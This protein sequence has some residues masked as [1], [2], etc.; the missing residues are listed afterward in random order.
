MI[1]ASFLPSPSYS[2][3]NDTGHFLQAEKHCTIGRNY[4]GV[5]SV[6]C[7]EQDAWVGRFDDGHLKFELTY[8]GQLSA[9]HVEEIEDE[10]I[11]NDILNRFRSMNSTCLSF[12]ECAKDEMLA[13]TVAGFDNC[14]HPLKILKLKH[15]LDLPD[16]HIPMTTEMGTAVVC[17]SERGAVLLDNGLSPNYSGRRNEPLSKLAPGYLDFF[18]FYQ[19]N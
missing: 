3:Q 14:P 15:Y 6:S 12:K 5:P 10:G 16:A 1:F 19:L 8:G 17:F 4:K 11:L 18:E 13:S 9:L 2:Q 7:L